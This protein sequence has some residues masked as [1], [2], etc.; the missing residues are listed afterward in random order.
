MSFIYWAVMSNSQ[1]SGKLSYIGL[2]ESKVF[3]SIYYMYILLWLES[4]GQC[5]IKN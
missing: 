2:Q 5:Y 3:L 4:N 1:Y